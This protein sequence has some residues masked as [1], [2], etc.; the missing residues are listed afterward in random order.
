M[1]KLDENSAGKRVRFRSGSTSVIK[2]I[3]GEWFDGWLELW[4]E[5]EGVN[6][7]FDSYYDTGQ[8]IP[9]NFYDTDYKSMWDIVEV[10]E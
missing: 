4:L 10:F 5:F 1:V 8:V 7:P 6:P 9:C 2:S 3:D